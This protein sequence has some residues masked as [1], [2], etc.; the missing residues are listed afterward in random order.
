[1]KTIV[2]GPPGTGKTTTLINLVYKYLK[3][4]DPD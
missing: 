4:P 1:M 2:I 3:K